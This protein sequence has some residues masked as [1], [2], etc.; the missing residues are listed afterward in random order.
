MKKTSCGLR[1]ANNTSCSCLWIVLTRP[2]GWLSVAMLCN[3]LGC[4]SAP[5]DG[6]GGGEPTTTPVWRTAFDTTDTGAL[7]AVW[8]SSSDDV[9]M[10]GG[11]RDQGEVYHFDGSQWR[12]MLVPSVP[13]LVWV[14]GFGPDDVFAV[15][16]GGGA[17]H[18]DGD[19]WTSLA[20]GTKEDLW[21]VWGSSPDDLWVVGGDVG[22]GD[23]VILHYDG[24][25]FT[26]SAIPENDRN[27]TSLFKVWG[28]GSKT[29][30][31]GENGLILEYDGGNW[32]QVAAGAAADDDFV[33]LWGTSENNIVA[34]GGRSSA[35]IARYD[36][37]T[38]TTEA[39]STTPGLNAVF[40][41]EPN[42]AVVGG[43][44]GFA[45]AF[46]PA[47][48]ELTIE[49][50]LTNLCL[51]GIW[52][53]TTSTF[54]GV[55]GRFSEPLAGLAIQRTLEA[56]SGDVDPPPPPPIHLCNADSECDDALVCSQGEC[57]APQPASIE[58][59]AVVGTIS[60]AVTDGGEI[61][62]FRG[63]QGG[64]HTFMTVR[65]EGFTP[66]GAATMTVGM[67]RD[68][69]GSTL[70]TTRN[71]PIRFTLGEDG[72]NAAE[73]IFVT[74]DR[75]QVPFLAGAVGTVSITVTDDASPS[76]S[77]SITRTVTLVEAG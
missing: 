44:N 68:I 24:T 6:G 12:E 37:S 17:I 35:R 11:T 18:Y 31:V 61:P 75:V 40:M 72:I 5:G 21:G 48:G 51:H 49:E 70:V 56:S 77:A 60:G 10:V 41:V 25:A 74:F 8:G 54:F 33:S 20:T 69:D 47:T 71:L 38:W 28:I 9:Y 13:L 2:A 66:D 15:G 52:G 57:I 1:G 76:I 14:F 50:S 34:V 19:R 3:G 29:F 63:F 59:W 62:L 26:A 39:F 42:V 7:S 58:Y 64:A 73:S 30:A 23:P 36:G 22:D 43:V 27:A 55:G 16:E 65:A 32:R 46:N 53:S 4:T 67:T 45:G